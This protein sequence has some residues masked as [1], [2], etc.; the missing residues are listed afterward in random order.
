LRALAEDGRSDVIF[1]MNNQSEKPGYGLQLK[2]GATSLTEAWD[3]N[4][5]DSQNHFMLGQIQ[6]WFYH[7]L[8]GIQNAP[9]SAG[10]QKIVIHPQPVGDVT[11]VKASYNSIRGKIATEWQRGGGK[12]ILKVT[13][14]ANTTAT[15]FVPAKSQEQVLES[16][17]P[18]A[19][20]AGVKFLRQEND[21]T[22]FETSSGSYEFTVK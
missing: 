1:D 14:P 21:Q 15:V 17:R 3:A 10:F 4:P 5:E 19:Q 16:G 8:A 22:V 18:A 11:W 2:R 13:I 12:F 7:D 9:G 20:S 6:E